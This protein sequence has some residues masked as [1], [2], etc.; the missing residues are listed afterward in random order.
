MLDLCEY[1]NG[2]FTDLFLQDQAID[3]L[4]FTLLLVT[5]R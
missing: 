4:S 1:F 5:F 2:G 3:W